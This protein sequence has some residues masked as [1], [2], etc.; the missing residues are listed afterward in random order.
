[1]TVYIHETIVNPTFPARRT[2]E[3]YGFQARES[4]VDPLITRS[5]MATMSF[6]TKFS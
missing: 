2:D 6:S 1:M 5:V 3:G 4:S